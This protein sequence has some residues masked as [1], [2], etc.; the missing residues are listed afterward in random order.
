[1]VEVKFIDGTPVSDDY[2]ISASLLVRDAAL[3]IDMFGDDELEAAT[4]ADASRCAQEIAA[5]CKPW[6]R[7]FLPHLGPAHPEWLGLFPC[8]PETRR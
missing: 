4:R 2:L 7:E 8:Q 3:A 5:E 6:R 1:M